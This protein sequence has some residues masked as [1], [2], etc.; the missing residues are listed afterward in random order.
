MFTL[1]FKAIWL[2][3][4][5]YTPNNFAVVIGGG[6]PIDLGRNF[7]DGKRIFGDGKTFRGFAGGV[8]G[9]VITGVVQYKVE[10][11]IGIQ[12]FSLLS[13]NDAILLFF[14]LSAGS[15]TG[16]MIGSFIKRRLGFERGEK[17][18]LLDQLDFLVFSIILA[19]FHKSFFLLYSMEV[20]LLGILVTPLLHRLTNFI[21][22]LLRLKDVPW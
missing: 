2:F 6:M 15:L 3:M 14:L 21:A 22:H 5:S 18:P 11:I 20:L 7:I 13:F 17:A 1:I 9:G 10:R 4:P 19:S 12:M 8:T 16:D